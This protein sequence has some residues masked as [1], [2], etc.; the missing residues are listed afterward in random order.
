MTRKGSQK[1]VSNDF[2]QGRLNNAHAFHDAAQLLLDSHETGQNTNP[3]IAQI[4][5]A[6]IAYADAVT[7]KRDNRI[8]QQDHQALGNLLRSV[9]GS[10]LPTNQLANLNRI[11]K[12]K[13]DASYG[14]RAGTLTQARDLLERLNKFGAWTDAELDWKVQP[15]L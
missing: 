3:I 12:E 5:A 10:R 4:V 7:A 11:L 1:A 13:D 6:A 15:N 8:N 9:L 2:W 14:I